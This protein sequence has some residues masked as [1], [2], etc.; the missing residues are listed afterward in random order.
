MNHIIAPMKRLGTKHIAFL[1][2][3]FCLAFTVQTQSGAADSIVDMTL[4]NPES[5]V[6]L[7][8]YASLTCS[9]CARFHQDVYPELK[10]DYIDTNK[11][12]FRFREV[13]FDRPGLWA[14]IVARCGGPEKY[15][16]IIDLL[17]SKQ[18]SWSAPN[19]PA[20][21]VSRLM[22][23]GRAAG[24]SDQALKA[25]LTDAAN[26]NQLNQ[27]WEKNRDEHDINSTPT[28]IINGKSHPNMPYD[29]LSELLDDA[30]GR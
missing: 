21:I 28:F 2:L 16:G 15:F 4:G 8:E 27:F 6:I 20:Q 7:T 29:E 19:D 26:A 25:C 14:S 11:I 18:R 17:F 1:L 9:H 5:P 23:I 3:I 12:Q 22:E 10:K 30:L 13:Y 24:L